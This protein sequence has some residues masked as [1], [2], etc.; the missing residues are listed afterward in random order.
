MGEP[1]SIGQER[2]IKDLQREVTDLH[3]EMTKLR[4]EV[5]MLRNAID[6]LA[7]GGIA[8]GKVCEG[9]RDGGLKVIE[10]VT[11]LN[12]VAEQTYARLDR[13]NEV[14]EQTYGRLDKLEQWAVKSGH[15]LSVPEGLK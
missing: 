15:T 11:I 4:A 5:E 6:Q 9:L 1:V 8:M 12:E 3:R 10:S 14:A 7:K 13:L 2:K